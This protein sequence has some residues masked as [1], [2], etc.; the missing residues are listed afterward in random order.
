DALERRPLIFHGADFDI[1]ML[2]RSY[3][4]HPRSGIFDSMLAAQLLGS[5][6]QGLADLARHYCG[7][8]LVK[9]GQK[10][11][12]SRRPLTAA[13]LEYASN[14][15][16]YL[17]SIR[18][19]MER[20]LE[21]LGRLGWLHQACD[22]LLNFLAIVKEDAPDP[23]TRWQ[24]KG[25]KELKGRALTILKALWEW[26]EAEAQNR[27][28]PSFKVFHGEDLIHMAKW[29]SA[30]AHPPDI[31]HLPNAPRSVKREAR[32]L[33]AV[34]REAWDAPQ[35][36]F[37][38]KPPVRHKRWTDRLHKAYLK[39][40]EA[41]EAKAKELKIQPSLLGTNAILEAIVSAAPG[42]F[43]ALNALNFLMPW[44]IDVM[45]DEILKILSA[46]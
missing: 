27:D 35:A 4:F 34:I 18:V 2:K 1:R 10:A 14:D 45:G 3:G 41:R 8:T 12:W 39:L 5:E 6:G 16:R 33:D 25:S 19:D 17:H 26:R 46:N 9:S 11:D 22:R 21:E 43:E 31:T 15:T 44:Q 42:D 38:T 13:L 24:I 23:G 32:L 20:E 36:H 7:V 28:R 40:K 30:H 37:Q 29:A